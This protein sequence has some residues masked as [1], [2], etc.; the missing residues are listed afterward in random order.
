MKFCTIIFITLL[1]SIKG[2]AQTY[3]VYINPKG[4]TSNDPKSAISYV[5]IKKIEDSVYLARQFDMHDTLVVQG[6]YK[7]SLMTIPNGRFF[8]YHKYRINYKPSQYVDT[9]SYLKYTGYFL[10]GVK[11]GKWIEYA[12]R[13]TKYCTYTFENNKLNGLYQSYNY[14]TGK[15]LLQGNYVEGKKEGE[16]NNYQNDD[17]KPVSTDVYLHDQMNKKIVHLKNA[18]PPKDFDNYVQKKLRHYMDSLIKEKVKVS[19]SLTEEGNVDS[20]IF[21][22]PMNQ[23]MKLAVSDVLVKSP[24]FKP[25]LYDDKP[26]KQIYIF[27]FADIGKLNAMQGMVDDVINQKNMDIRAKHADD[28][29]RGLNNMGIGKPVN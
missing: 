1:F 4:E 6:T 12:D 8:Y 20:V 15:L 19:I 16:W 27:D 7:D 18:I 10:N 17:Q 9:N 24:Q 25:A 26:F 11:T 23:A 2:F 3:K 13:Y 22:K 29:G 14:R 5:L 28:I 21:T